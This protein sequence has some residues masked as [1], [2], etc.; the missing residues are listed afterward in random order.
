M[1]R[2]VPLGGP[3]R[4]ERLVSWYY[5]EKREEVAKTMLLSAACLGV[6]DMSGFLDRYIQ[7]VFPSK[8]ANVDFLQKNKEVL[9]QEAKKQYNLKEAF[10]RDD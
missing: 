8:K 5:E 3:L 2:G 1:S 6:E 7:S 9:E 10:R 4:T